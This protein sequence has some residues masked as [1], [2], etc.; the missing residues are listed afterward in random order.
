MKLAT[1]N[2]NVT[3]SGNAKKI[4][5]VDICFSHMYE[6]N[7]WR[8]TCQSQGHARSNA[9][10]CG[11]DMH[12]DGMSSRLAC[13]SHKTTGVCRNIVANDSYVVKFSF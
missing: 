3:V 9:L 7:K 2:N 6:L 10:L 8:W 5:N 12:F 13:F 4:S 1:N 11:G